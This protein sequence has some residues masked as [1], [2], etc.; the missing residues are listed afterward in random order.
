MFGTMQADTREAIRRG[1][2]PRYTLERAMKQGLV[3]KDF[4]DDVVKSLA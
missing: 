3:G 2:V 4:I 1:I